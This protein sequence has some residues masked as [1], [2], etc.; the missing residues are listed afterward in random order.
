MKDKIIELLKQ[1]EDAHTQGVYRCDYD[2]LAGDIVKI[3]SSNSMLADSKNGGVEKMRRWCPNCKM[4]TTQYVKLY[5]PDNA[6]DGEVWECHY[7]EEN[8]GWASW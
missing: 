8:T 5:N 6:E 7:C 2:E 1:Y 4:E 3:F